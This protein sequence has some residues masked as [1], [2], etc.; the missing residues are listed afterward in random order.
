MSANQIGESFFNLAFA[1]FW[2]AVWISKWTVGV[3]SGTEITLS[4]PRPN[5]VIAQFLDIA[6][7][8]EGVRPKIISKDLHF[9]TVYIFSESV[10]PNLCLEI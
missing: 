8:K 4:G 1:I 9:D 2:F 10:M 5:E 7:D 6:I 3:V